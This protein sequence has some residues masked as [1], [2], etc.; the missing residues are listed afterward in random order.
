MA[1]LTMV[2]QH[3]AGASLGRAGSTPGPGGG[4]GCNCH[5]GSEFKF[6]SKSR[7]VDV[8]AFFKDSRSVLTF[9]A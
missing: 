4:G 5:C 6:L 1:T 2:V 8:N 3:V 9:V 7:P